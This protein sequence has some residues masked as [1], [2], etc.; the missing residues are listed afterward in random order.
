MCLMF[1][2]IL[3]A[4]YCSC[5]VSS[6]TSD[7][8][9][10]LFSILRNLPFTLFRLEWSNPLRLSDFISFLSTLCRAL[11]GWFATCYWQPRRQGFEYL[12]QGLVCLHV[13]RLGTEM[14]GTW[15]DCMIGAKRSEGGWV[16]CAVP[17]GS[18]TL[19]NLR[20]KGRWKDGKLFHDVPCAN[21]GPSCAGHEP[22]PWPKNPF[23][24]SRRFSIIKPVHDSS[25]H[26]LPLA[27][28]R[29]KRSAPDLQRGFGRATHR[30]AVLPVLGEDVKNW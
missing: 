30:G 13:C 7:I 15:F 18:A 20:C 29:G 8:Y 3:H 10:L 23:K 19:R 4:L 28:W 11:R 1:D 21:S 25:S 5:F 17:G 26:V 24:S 6:H 16:Y 14:F 27:Y 12:W 22:S 2:F 9:D